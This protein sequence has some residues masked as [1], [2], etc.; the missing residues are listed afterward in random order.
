MKGAATKRHK[1]HRTHTVEDMP[2]TRRKGS[3]TGIPLPLPACLSSR[4]HSS[5]G[6]LRGRSPALHWP[7]PG[8]G[9][10]LPGWSFERVDMLCR[11]H[12]R[13]I[14][15]TRSPLP[16]SPGIWGKPLVPY[17]QP[18]LGM[19]LLEKFAFMNRLADPPRH[20]ISANAFFL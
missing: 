8:A 2:T 15:G 1:K 10:P 3:P 5:L 14:Q 16:V 4:L 18:L 7:W 9:K 12:A 13:Y 20:F 6:S 11:G 19:S 17:P